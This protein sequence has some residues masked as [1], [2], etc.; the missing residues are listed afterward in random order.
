VARAP[1]SAVFHLVLIKPSHYD[2]DGYPIQWLRSAIPS[3]TLA[4][5]NGLAEDCRR[6][7]VLG[8]NVDIKISTF[9]ETNRRVCPQRII[10]MIESGGGRALVAFVGVQSNQFPRALDIARP[11]RGRKIPVCIG[12]FH[13]SGCTSMLDELH[14]SLQEARAL[15]ISLYA[16][17]AE[18]RLDEVLTDAYGG[19]L[20][21]IYNY[22][23]DLPDLTN[24]PLPILPE[25]HVRRTAGSHSSVDLGRGCP[26]QCS[27]CTIINVQGRKS[28]Y[29]TPDDLERT[30]RE[31]YAQGINR[32]FITDDN[33]A[34]NRNW[35][36]FF[37]RMIWLR[38][39]QGFDIKFIIQVDTLCH[40]IPNFIEKASRAGVTRAFIGLENINPDSLL[41]AKKRQNRITDYRAMLQA[42]KSAGVLTYA[43]YII[44][45]PNDRK[46]TVLRDIEII[47]RELPIDIL[48]LF[49]LTPLPGSEDHKVL[50]Q[51]GAWMDADLNK[52]DLNHRVSHHPLMSD[53]EWEETY[54]AAWAAFYTPEHIET[55]M[56]RAVACNMSP[57]RA[58]FL[59]L[60]FLICVRYE[61]VHPLEGGYFRLRYRKDR[62]PTLPRENPLVFYSRYLSHLALMQLRIVYWALR[63]NRARRAIKSDKNRLEYTDLSLTP[64]AEY[65]FHDL[66]LF[67]QTRGGIEVVAKKLK[68]DAARQA[69][70]L[71][72]LEPASKS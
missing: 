5:L 44:G 57:G 70:P 27:F 67:G 43:G 22:M 50:C 68:Q 13:V 66:A 2:D 18:G 6:R 35:E 51:K 60:W 14:V 20:K 34:R 7:K 26:F 52:Y 29:R 63:M 37:D 42:W 58:M 24:H 36:S 45:F 25:R 28:R 17:E 55:V 9:D 65:E 72:Q 19:A 8:K 53:E 3:N 38:E 49:Y 61:G 69:N 59:G 31:N 48:E 15:G 54:R 1:I 39:E 56:R 47:K 46:E 4:C 23:R 41:G 71:R 62:R 40:K 12:G 21:P 33:F 16:G 11:F 64:S 32:F 10:R 30:V